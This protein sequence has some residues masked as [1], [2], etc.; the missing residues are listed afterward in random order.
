[1]QIIGPFLQI[2]YPN[3]DPNRV[4]KFEFDTRDP[5]DIAVMAE[6]IPKLVD[7]GVQI[8]ESWV[9]DKLVIPEPAE[10]ERVLARVVPDNPVHQA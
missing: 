6:A 8:P 3:A 4:P 10:G 7:V 2:N 1:S 9:R 5:E